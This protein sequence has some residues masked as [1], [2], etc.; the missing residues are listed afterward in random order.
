LRVSLTRCEPNY[1]QSPFRLA[2]CACSVTSVQPT[3]PLE[4]IESENALNRPPAAGRQFSIVSIVVRYTGNGVAKMINGLV[5][6]ALGQSGKKYDA[7]LDGCGLVPRAIDDLTG[8][9]GQTVRARRPS[10]ATFRAALA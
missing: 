3:K 2:R 6:Y 8:R 5:F 1:K 7:Q 10:R 4:D 9:A